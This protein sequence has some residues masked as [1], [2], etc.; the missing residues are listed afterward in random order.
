MNLPDCSQNTDQQ[1]KL[2][3]P[4]APQYTASVVGEF[5]IC[6]FDSKLYEL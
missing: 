5:E 3:A 1:T 2:I 6:L 4:T